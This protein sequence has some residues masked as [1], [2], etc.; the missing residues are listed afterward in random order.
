MKYKPP[1]NRNLLVA[2]IIAGLDF[3]RI[4]KVMN[5]LEWSY[6]GSSD[7]PSVSQLK[8]MAS[9]MLI[10]MLE[11]GHVRQ[12]MGGFEAWRDGQHFGIRFVVESCATSDFE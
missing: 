10:D 2:G 9:D 11:K 3:D 4:A 7:A 5:H 6:D 8:E 12:A 1:A